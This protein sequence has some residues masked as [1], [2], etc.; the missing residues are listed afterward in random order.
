VQKAAIKMIAAE[1]RK[2]QREKVK[3]CE[4]EKV[5]E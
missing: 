5:K 1:I 4:N 2:E 3:E